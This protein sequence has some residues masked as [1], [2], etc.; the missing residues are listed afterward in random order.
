MAIKLLDILALHIYLQYK[1]LSHVSSMF[2]LIAV[3]VI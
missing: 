3:H 2:P 1:K